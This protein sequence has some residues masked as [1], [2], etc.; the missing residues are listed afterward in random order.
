MTRAWPTHWRPPAGSPRLTTKIVFSSFVLV[1]SL[2]VFISRTT[3]SR[4]PLAERLCSGSR[5]GMSLLSSDRALSITDQTK[6]Q[7]NHQGMQHWFVVVS[8]LHSMF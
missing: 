6:V 8:L 7:G 2:S 4:V 3:P 5:P 1:L